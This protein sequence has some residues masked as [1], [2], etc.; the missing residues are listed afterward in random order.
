MSGFLVFDCDGTLVDSQFM[1]VAAMNAAFDDVGL[2]R[3]DANRVRR[4]VGLSLDEAIWRLLPEAER[5]LIL[6]LSDRYKQA[7][8]TARESG[9]REPF[10][11]GA[12]EAILRL[13]AAGYLL[14]VATGKS[15]RGLVAVLEQAGLMS[16][17]VSLQT[18]D[19]A[20]G[21]P[22][23]AMLQQAMREAG[24]DA[25]ETLMIG[26][27]SYDMEMARAAG[28]VGLGV[29]WGY[30]AP[31]ELLTAGA[32]MVVDDYSTLERRVPDLLMVKS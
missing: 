10:Y 7:F 11:P 22:H 13:S 4:V 16:H 14:G 18:A 19:D 15:R 26:D 9:A 24:A 23:P 29:S 28:V 20:P 31:S 27:T 32:E 17:F 8:R 6:A 2:P 21:K 1:I 25:A 30:H 5:G 12:R 3:P